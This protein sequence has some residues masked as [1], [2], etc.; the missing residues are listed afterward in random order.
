[1]EEIASWKE[2]SY[3]RSGLF[4]FWSGDGK[5]LVPK[6]RGTSRGDTSW[7]DN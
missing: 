2:I 7:G 5:E 1:M 3:L 6:P 4:G